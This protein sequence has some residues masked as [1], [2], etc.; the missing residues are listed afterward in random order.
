MVLYRTAW[1]FLKKL[2]IQLPYD[3]TI[4][5]LGFFSNLRKPWFK[6]IHAL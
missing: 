2:K 1:R 5:F 3:P 4:P 6:R